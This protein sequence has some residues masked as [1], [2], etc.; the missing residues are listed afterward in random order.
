MVTTATLFNYDSHYIG[1]GSRGSFASNWLYGIEAVY[2]G[3]R[4]LSSSFTLDGAGFLVPNAQTRDS[5]NAFALD[6]QVDYL[7]HDPTQARI[8]GEVLLA[9]GDSDRILNTTNTFG[10]NSPNTKDE[11]FNG[12]GLMNTG[13]AFAPSVSNLMM[14][15]LGASSFPFPNSGM[16]KRMQ[17]GTNVFVFN[18]L[19][20]NAPIDED[21]SNSTYVGSEIDVWVNWQVSSDVGVV[22]RYGVFFPGSAIGGSVTGTDHDTRHFLY[23]GLTLSF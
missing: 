12:F 14:F 10:G 20:S 9:T 17:L 23:T 22:T 7:Y 11:A 3:G 21:S 1:I 18:K 15:R 16:L 8:S 2:Q 13:L 4:T 19:N 5:I 6:A